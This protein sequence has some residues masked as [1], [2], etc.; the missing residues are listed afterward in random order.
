MSSCS[1]FAVDLSAT[2]FF[3]IGNNICITASSLSV[4]TMDL[5]ILKKALSHP[6]INLFVAIFSSYGDGGKLFFD[7][8]RRLENLKFIHLASTFAP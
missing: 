6:E 8:K 5:G 7:C 2:Y 1:L 3:C 4:T